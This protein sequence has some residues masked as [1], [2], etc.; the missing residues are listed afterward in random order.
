MNL[1]NPGIVQF[2][3]I[4]GLVM[5]V[6]FFFILSLLYTTTKDTTTFVDVNGSGKRL[7]KINNVLSSHFGRSWPTLFLI[8]G[9]FMVVILVL[10]IVNSTKPIELKLSDQGSFHLTLIALCILILLVITVIL[11]FLNYYL[12]D[13]DDSPGTIDSRKKFLINVGAVLSV[14]FIGT[15]VYAYFRK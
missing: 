15:V 1:K 7:T 10:L 8:V 6:L 5:L 14:I 13:P 11:V 4:L 3:L 12:K 2:A 9:I